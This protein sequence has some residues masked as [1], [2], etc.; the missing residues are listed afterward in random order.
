MKIYAHT[1]HPYITTD[2]KKKRRAPSTGENLQ[3][4]TTSNP[5]KERLKTAPT[6]N[7]THFGN[8][9]T[10]NMETY[11]ATLQSNITLDVKK[12]KEGAPFTI[13][14]LV[15]QHNV[16]PYTQRETGAVDGYATQ[17]SCHATLDL[18]LQHN[19]RH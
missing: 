11:K 1:L 5:G 15:I 13:E 9:I 16:R 6:P 4:N 14:N 8:S 17:S 3:S 7:T 19:V 10:S 2:V 18:V 12:K